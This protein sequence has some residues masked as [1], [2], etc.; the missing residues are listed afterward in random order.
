M[1]LA[2]QADQDAALT[3]ACPARPYGCSAPAGQLCV[4][5]D[6]KT[7][8]NLPAHTHRLHAAGV[9]HAPIDPRE[10]RRPHERTPR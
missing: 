4:R 7:L 5:T 9:V 6:G 2:D 1:N 10:L 8:E 3:V